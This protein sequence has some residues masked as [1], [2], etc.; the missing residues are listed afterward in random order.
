MNGGLT[1]CQG[2]FLVNPRALAQTSTWVLSLFAIPKSPVAAEDV[3]SCGWR[4]Q[5]GQTAILPIN[6]KA[7]GWCKRQFAKR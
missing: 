1:V 5:A 2:S 3:Q 7:Q 4:A 6:P